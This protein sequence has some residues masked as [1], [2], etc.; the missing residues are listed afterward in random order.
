M[1]KNVLTLCI[2]LGFSVLLL[3]GC[4][5]ENANS[6]TCIEG[7]LSTNRTNTAGPKAALSETQ[8]LI[9]KWIEWVVSRDYDLVPW[10]DATGDK[11]YAAQPYAN[12]TMLLAGGG[13]PDLVY[14]AITIDLN[15]YQQIFIPVVNVFNY[16]SDCFPGHPEK[17]VPNG[18]LSHYLTEPLNGKRTLILSWD[19]NS[20]LPDKLKDLRENSGFWEAPVHPSWTNGCIS[21]S[22]T[23]Y[24]DGFWAKIPLT[25]GVH[26]LEVAG[27][28]DFKEPFSN[29]VIYT[30]TVN[31]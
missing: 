15:Q 9:R 16:W 22:T 14:R 13:S 4:R 6:G 17:N 11:Q 1:K 20:L 8:I 7:N 23:F 28:L 21:S 3:Q 27:D 2:T 12:G 31:K 25:P 29:H 19:G 26:N 10:D 30:I 5:K 18:G 24:A